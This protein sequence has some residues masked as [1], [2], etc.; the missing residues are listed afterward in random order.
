[1]PGGDRLV[2][3]AVRRCYYRGRYRCD[4]YG[5]ARRSARPCSAP[6]RPAEPLFG[7][8]APA[9]AP[10][11]ADPRSFVGLVGDLWR[12][13][14]K[15]GFSAAVRANT[16]RLRGAGRGEMARLVLGALRG[17]KLAGMLDV[18]E[19]RAGL[20]Q[21]LDVCVRVRQVHALRDVAEPGRVPQRVR[22]RR[23]APVDAALALSMP[24]PLAPTA[25]EAAI[26]AAPYRRCWRIRHPH[27]GTP[28]NRS[29]APPPP[30]SPG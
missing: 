9:P 16:K 24:L 25:P 6:G 19:R 23:D 12:S 30:R 26:D 20:H 8:K 22:E 1:M 14:D 28:R 3:H 27:H 4:R 5:K 21:H 11:G 29:G 18:Q 2:H 10:M 15:G 13:M 17:P 7:Q